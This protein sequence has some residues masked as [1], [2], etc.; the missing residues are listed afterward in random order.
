MAAETQQSD[1]GKGRQVSPG[2]RILIGVVIGVAVGVFL[3]SYSAPIKVAGDVYLALLQ[4][5]VL[6]Y[7]VV[8]LISKIGGF[9]YERAKQ[10]ILK[11]PGFSG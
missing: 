6:P 5:T 3:G 10:R 4:M 8:S 2:T 1:A 7:I 11:H 9:T